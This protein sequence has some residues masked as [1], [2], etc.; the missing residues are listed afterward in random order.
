MRGAFQN[1]RGL[2]KSDILQC[3]TDF[4]KDNNLDFIGLQDTKKEKN[5]ISFI[6]I[7]V[8]NGCPFLLKD[9]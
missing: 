7:Q 3:V 1:I 4:V 6:Q 9:L 5:H 8:L 2:N